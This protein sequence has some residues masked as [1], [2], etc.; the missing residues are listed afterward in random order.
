MSVS[1]V[2]DMSYRER[3]SHP[4]RDEPYRSRG[5]REP[6]EKRDPEESRTLFMRNLPYDLEEEEL[7]ALL[8]VHGEL[9]RT[10]NMLPRK[11][12]PRP[13]S[14]SPRPACTLRRTTTCGTR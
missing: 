14:T 4:H 10:F 9:S 6:L 13:P 12:Y 1:V 3:P 11:G 5:D 8:R 2:L 7:L